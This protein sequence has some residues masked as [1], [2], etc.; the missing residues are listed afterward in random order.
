MKDLDIRTI[1][2]HHGSVLTGN[3]EPYYRAIWEQDFTGLPETAAYSG[4]NLM[5]E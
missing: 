4:P 1:A 5:D 2:C 3:L